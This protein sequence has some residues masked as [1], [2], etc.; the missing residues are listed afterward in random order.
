LPPKTVRASNE[1]QFENKCSTVFC[2]YSPEAATSCSKTTFNL[3]AHTGRGRPLR[4]VLKRTGVFILS[5]FGFNSIRRGY[6]VFVCSTVFSFFG[7]QVITT[8]VQRC[9]SLKN[10]LYNTDQAGSV[11]LM[12]ERAYFGG[13]VLLQDENIGY[14]FVH[15]SIFRTTGFSTKWITTSVLPIPARAALVSF[16]FNWP[17]TVA[18]VR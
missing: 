18:Y 13:S 7:N 14:P 8:F 5:A 3:S 17:A 6:R 16:L 1:K 4:S 2:D 11:Q 12:I 9:P 15:P 10:G